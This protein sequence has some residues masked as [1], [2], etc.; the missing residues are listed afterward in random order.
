VIVLTLAL[1][2]IGNYYWKQNEIGLSPGPLEEGL[3]GHYNLDG[4]EKDSSGL[5]NDGVSVYGKV[6][7]VDDAERGKVAKFGGR[8]YISLD[9]MDGEIN[10][11]GG[12]I[13]VWIK[14]EDTN[15]AKAGYVI[16]GVGAN[17]NRYYLQWYKWKTWSKP[18]FRF[19][20]GNPAVCTK[21]KELSLNNWHNVVMVWRTVNGVQKMKGYVDGV[22]V[23]VEKPFKGTGAGGSFKIGSARYAGTDFKGLIDDVRFYNRALS[24]AEIKGL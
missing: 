6:S 3:I 17:A 7:Y 13:S 20:K 18:R 22:L 19:C 9:S 14:P 16:N 4:N 12:T 1:I 15:Q 11:N 24:E 23:D 21:W 10:P 2:L 8:Y 5:G